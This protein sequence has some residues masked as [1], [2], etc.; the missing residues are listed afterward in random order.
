LCDTISNGSESGDRISATKH[1]GCV[2]NE[3]QPLKQSLR[4]SLDIRED[5]QIPF[6]D[7]TLAI[8]I[9]VYDELEDIDAKIDS[10]IVKQSVDKLLDFHEKQNT[11]PT[12]YLTDEN[13]LMWARLKKKSKQSKDFDDVFCHKIHKIWCL[14]DDAA[15][16]DEENS[17]REKKS[18][19][20]KKTFKVRALNKHGKVSTYPYQS[21]FWCK[22]PNC[23]NQ[24]P[25]KS[26]KSL[27]HH[28]KVFHSL[29]IQPKSQRRAKEE[30]SL[31]TEA[32]DKILEREIPNPHRTDFAINLA[33]EIKDDFGRNFQTWL[34]DNKDKG[35]HVKARHLVAMWHQEFSGEDT[36]E[37]MIAILERLSQT[38]A[39]INQIKALSLKTL[40]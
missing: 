15:I 9:N 14:W 26:K 22:A 34:D 7:R 40:L 30:L 5:F 3:G 28:A 19:S 4:V 24:G 29:D 16:A 31:A 27:Q 8:C 21:L 25:L 13:I 10:D 17:T 35:S 33:Y 39:I 20:S 37:A 1:L 11:I 2:P 18:A 23:S 32:L 12:E 6:L 36:P 38:R